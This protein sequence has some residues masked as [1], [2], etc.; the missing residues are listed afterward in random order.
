M[1]NLNKNDKAY[2]DKMAGPGYSVSG[3]MMINHA[4]DGVTGIQQAAAI[5]KAARRAEKVSMMA[6]ATYL[7]Y[8]RAEMNE[9]MN[10]GC[11]E[12]D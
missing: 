1:A 6:D 11:E 5:R 10:G 9:M 12:C 7:G 2:Q 8:S 4:P 3:G